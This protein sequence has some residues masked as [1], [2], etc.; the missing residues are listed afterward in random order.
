MGSIAETGPGDGTN[1]IDIRSDTSGIELRQEI[2]TGLRPVGG[3][4]KTLPTLLLYDVQ[5][6]RL[7]ERITY[8]EE[9]YL[10]GEEIKLLKEHSE[11]IAKRITDDTIIV[12]LGSGNLRKIRILLDALEKAQKKVTYYALDLMETEL[13]RTL[14]DVPDYKYVRCFGLH[15]TYDDGLKWLQRSE[16]VKKPKAVLS[17]GSSIGNFTR[18]EAAAFIQHVFSALNANDQLFIALDGCQ[19]ADKVYHAYNDCEGITHQ[20]VANGLQHANR[21]LGYEAFVLSDW[22]VIGEYDEKGGR[23]RAFVAPKRDLEVEGVAIQS[24]ERVRIEESYKYE[25][26]SKTERSIEVPSQANKLWQASGVLEAASWANQTGEYA[27]F[28]LSKRPSTMFATKP[29]RYAAHPVPSLDE[30]SQLWAVWDLVTRQMIPDEELHDKPIKLRNACIFYLGHIPTFF[31]MKL[32]EATGGDPTEPK[33]FYSIFERGIDPDVDNPEHCHA[34]SEIPDTW[35]DVKTILKFQEGVRNRLTGLYK[36]GKA[37]IDA[38]TG[39]AIWLGFEHEVM[40]LETLL[41][42]LLQSDWC[43]SPA[44]ASKPDFE[45]LANKAHDQSVDNEW[46]DIPEQ[47]I[48]TGLDDPDNAEGPVR[49][50]GWDVEKPVK[51][52]K[53]NAFKAKGRPIINAEYVRFMLGTGKTKLPASWQIVETPKSDKV[54]SGNMIGDSDLHDFVHDKAVRTVYGP[55][56]LKYALDWPVSASYDELAACAKYMDGRIPTLEEARSI[57]YYAD[58]LKKKE[59]AQAS[60]RTIP[61][62]NGHLVNE[63]VEETPPSNRSVDGASAAAGLDPNML[64]VNLDEANVGFKHWHPMPVTQD[65]G[66]LAGQGEMGGLWEWTSSALEKQE[67]F[68]PMKLYPA[69]SADFYDKKHNVVLGGS[70]A[71]HPRLAGRKSS[72]NWYQRNYPYAWAGARLV[73]DN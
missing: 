16:N 66:K 19:N 8:L 53:V 21:L 59:A 46:F 62:V 7:F 22:Y 27:L 34:H 31:D 35:P 18:D 33:Y 9:Y 20:F 13:Q 51:K 24:G 28:L 57:Y 5:G 45:K 41:Y 47:T 37:Y 52:V 73:K 58:Y 54:L 56:P 12:E 63:G 67:G 64:F 30:W 61:A 10:T 60:G 43:K 26:S 69:Y 65:G 36:G 14:A 11:S 3:A 40:H 39:R 44:T 6:L 2:L 15:G 38:W 70:W 25:I 49:H 17:L 68:V 72:V 48:E 71:T 50:F 55:I 1:I 23:H 42:M 4:E 32:T 29:E